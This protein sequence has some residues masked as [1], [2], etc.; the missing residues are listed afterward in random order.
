MPHGDKGL[1]AH[2][3]EDF[4]RTFAELDEF[5]AEMTFE[6]KEGRGKAIQFTTMVVWDTETLKNRMIVQQQGV[7]LGSVLLF[8]AK[9]WFE[10][11]PKPDE[12]IYEL[13][14][15]GKLPVRFGWRILDVVDAEFIYEVSLDR[16]TV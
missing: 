9:K 8:I 10:V 5:A 7:Y 4:D 11:E 13:T 16:L 15:R 6:I 14:Y 2:F 1:S 12:I 3:E